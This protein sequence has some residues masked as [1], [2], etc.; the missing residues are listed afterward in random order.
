MPFSQKCKEV[1]P[2]NQTITGRI[3]ALYT[4]AE[5][6]WN[7]HGLFRNIVWFRDCTTFVKMSWWQFLASPPNHH[8]GRII[9]SFDPGHQ[10]TGFLGWPCINSTVL[11]IESFL[12]SI[13]FFI[14]KDDFFV[15]LFTVRQQ[16]SWFCFL[17]SFN[18][19]VR[20][21]HI[22]RLEAPIPSLFDNATHGSA[23]YQ[24]PEP[25]FSVF[26]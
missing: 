9:T 1:T 3:M 5:S 7:I 21:C 26:G 17:F 8:W 19:T 24:F 12:H 4:G 16:A 25:W 15:M 10:F 14:C 23:Q 2:P 18:A 6:C 20:R 13:F 22:C 11:L